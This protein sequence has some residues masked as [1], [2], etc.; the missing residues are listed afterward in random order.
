M[1]LLHEPL[2]HFLLLGGVLFAAY[3]LFAAD[4]AEATD[5]IVVTQGRIEHLAT[6]FARTWQRSPS[7]RELQGLVED[8][9]REEVFYR[10]ALAIGLDRDDTVIHVR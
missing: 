2:L 9:V 3:S 5:R 8:Y 4:D 1:R 7:P 6:T 10:E